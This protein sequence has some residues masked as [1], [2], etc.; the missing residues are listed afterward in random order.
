M[1]FVLVGGSKKLQSQGH[2]VINVSRTAKG[3]AGAKGVSYDH[4]AEVCDGAQAVIN[5]AG[6]NI[7]AERWST[8][9]MKELID[10]RIG[11]TRAIV[12]A[13]ASCKE[14]PAL[15]SMSG[16][17]YYGRTTV[18]SNEGVGHGHNFPALIC[19]EWELEA[20][21]AKGSARRIAI[22]RMAP[23]LDPKDGPL[24]RMMP[25]VNRFMGGVLG[26]GK[27]WFPWVHRDDAVD[28]IIWA[29]T[30][31]SA[32]GPYNIVA[33]DVV[34]MKQFARTLGKVTRKPMPL[35]VPTIILLLLFGR[36]AVVV[37]G[38]TNARPS[39]ILGTSFRFRYPTLKGAL[40][41]LVGK[42]DQ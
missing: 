38:S 2:E 13:I 24:G 19:R 15:I 39:R 23:L 16:T 17:G 25:W 11:P 28:A 12:D 35:P 20:L 8:A 34:T 22:L 42:G 32:S 10:S 31:E 37:Y 1:R 26:S 36:M 4:L 6:A 18:P 3:S 30:E 21:K 29:A 9:R 33:P 27:Q 14:K 40:E 7:G 41:N 5:L